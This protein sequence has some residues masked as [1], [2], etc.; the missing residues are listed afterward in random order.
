MLHKSTYL[1]PSRPRA[2]PPLPPGPEFSQLG[3]VWQVGDQYDM[4]SSQAPSFTA[5]W[6]KS[7]SISK[8]KIVSQKE[9]SEEYEIENWKASAGGVDS[10]VWFWKRFIEHLLPTRHSVKHKGCVIAPV[11]KELAFRQGERNNPAL[12]KL[13]EK[14]TATH[15]STLA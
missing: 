2:C 6:L 13:V 8:L 7:I 5:N 11:L 9:I 10:C 12:C 15:P 4:C 1:I 14:E 3:A